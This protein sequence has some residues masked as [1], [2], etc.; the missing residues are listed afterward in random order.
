MLRTYHYHKI[1]KAY[2]ETQ[3]YT[4]ILFFLAWAAILLFFLLLEVF[5]FFFSFLWSLTVKLFVAALC[6]KAYTAHSLKKLS[7]VILCELGNG[8]ESDAQFL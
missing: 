1:N 7:T 8:N 6:N 3:Y 5:F 2:P 4:S